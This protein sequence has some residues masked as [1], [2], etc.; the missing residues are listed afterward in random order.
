[1]RNLGCEIRI[2]VY[3]VRIETCEM[4]IEMCGMRKMWGTK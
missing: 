4:R 1:M 2:D 3:E